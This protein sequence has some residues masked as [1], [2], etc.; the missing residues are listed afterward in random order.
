MGYGCRDLN[1]A[2]QGGVGVMPVEAA[3][4]RTLV[5]RTLFN[6]TQFDQRYSMGYKGA[7]I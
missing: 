3:T 1:G 5:D 7:R 2:P 4:N 6:P